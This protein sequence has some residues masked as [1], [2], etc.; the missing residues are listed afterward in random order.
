MFI[1][2]TFAHIEF[3]NLESSPSPTFYSEILFSHIFENDGDADNFV[4]LNYI[5]LLLQ[6]IFLIFRVSL[7]A[8]F[9]R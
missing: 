6:N 9:F 5:L 1:Q 2:R 7:Y 4:D 3:D 8:L